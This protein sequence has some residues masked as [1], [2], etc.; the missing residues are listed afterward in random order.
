MLTVNISSSQTA[1]RVPRKK[2][3]AMAQ[4]IARSEAVK[5]EEIDIAIVSSPRMAELNMQYLQHAGDTDVLSFDL[6]APGS[7]L[8]AQIIVCAEVAIRE[9]RARGLGPQREL[10]LY[11]AHGLLHVIGYDDKD[12]QQAEKMYARQQELL[13]AFLASYA[14]EAC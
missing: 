6:S 7:P 9:A 4:F 2:I 13:E 1:L 14:P 11:I 10:L 8:V 3:N 5:F 12:P